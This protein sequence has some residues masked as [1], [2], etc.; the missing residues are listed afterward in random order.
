MVRSIQEKNLQ[1]FYETGFFCEYD[2][3][4]TVNDQNFVSKSLLPYFNVKLIGREYRV[5]VVISSDLYSYDHPFCFPAQFLTFETKY[6][7]EVQLALV[8]AMTINSFIK[9][10]NVEQFLDRFSLLKNEKIKEIKLII[11]S[12]LS[13][14]L[15]NERIEATCT[16][17]KKNRSIQNVC[18]NDL[19]SNIIGRSKYI[20]F[21]EN[22]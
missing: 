6:E 5:F 8:T 14:L 20:Y 3:N 11:I 17:V 7:F 2:Q 16:L 10:F 15:K 1:E 22:L 4:W 12:S 13:S 21:K 9:E 18:I 19:N